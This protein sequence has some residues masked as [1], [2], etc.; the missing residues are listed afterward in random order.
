MQGVNP[1]RSGS[2]TI[3]EP[4]T[5]GSNSELT[6]T[7]SQPHKSTSSPPSDPSTPAVMT[8]P[9]LAERSSSNTS[10]SHLNML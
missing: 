10:L 1:A 5:S 7:N 2:S 3:H 6:P 4:S 9:G 8:A